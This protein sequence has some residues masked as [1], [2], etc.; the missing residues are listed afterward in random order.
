MKRNRVVNK[1]SH[2]FTSW[3][4]IKLIL[5]KDFNRNSKTFSLKYKKTLVNLDLMLIRDNI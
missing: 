2:N 3:E 4:N 5:D 1:C